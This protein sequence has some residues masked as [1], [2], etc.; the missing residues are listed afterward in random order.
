MSNKKRSKEA[1]RTMTEVIQECI[2]D[3]LS[4]ED[5][6]EELKRTFPGKTA[7]S[8]RAMVNKHYPQGET[9]AATSPVKIEKL[10]KKELLE[11]LRAKERDG[12]TGEHSEEE[13]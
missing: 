2:N 1:T 3:G 13:V 5:T 4:K 11:M 12:E 6:R 8:I 10:S 7:D 9:S